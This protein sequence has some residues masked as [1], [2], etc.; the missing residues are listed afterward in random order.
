MPERHTAASKTFT[1]LGGGGTHPE[2]ELLRF[3]AGPDG[4]IHPDLTGK[5][6]TP[7]Q[8]YVLPKRH[9]V[10]AAA[11]ALATLF[12]C[13][14]DGG[15]LL[16]RTV[17]QVRKRWLGSLGL[18]RKSGA[19]SLG[20]DKVCDGLQA[21]DIVLVLLARDTAAHTR[22]RVE[23]VAKAAGVPVYALAGRDDMSAALGQQ[24]CAVVGV[25]DAP[26]A[27]TVRIGAKRL[28]EL[29]NDR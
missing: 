8:A 10:L 7:Q 21:D 13:P 22:E 24:N 26:Q 17:A 5:L 9:Y 2:A 28:H 16:A 19:L 12:G 3:V 14:C 18:A 23:R 1:C 6:K 29:E 20:T 27:A 4:N 11:P 15:D 25:H